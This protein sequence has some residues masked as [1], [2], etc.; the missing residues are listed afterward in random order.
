[1]KIINIFRQPSFFL[2][3]TL[4]FCAC[5]FLYL[6]GHEKL[7]LIEAIDNR[8]MNIMFKLRGPQPVSGQVVIVDIDEKSLSQI[9][10]WPWPR[11]IMA[12]ITRNLINSEARAIGFDIVFAEKDR[13]SPSFFF[14]NLDNALLEKIPDS[15]LSSLAQN[16]SFDYD[17]FFGQALSFGPTVLGYGFQLKNDGLKTREALPFP[18]GM[19]RIKPDGLNFEDL[20]FIRAYRASVNH[21]SV[22]MAESEGFMNVYTDHSGTAR[23][24]PLFMLMDDIP[25]P[26]LALEVFRIG[27]K[28]S[29]LTIHATDKI[30]TVKKPIIGIQLGSQFV[31]TDGVGQIFVNYRGPV[32]SFEY[33][34]AIDVLNKELMPVFKD[35]FVLVGTS[36]TGLFDLKAT[37]FSRAVPGVEI[38]A[39]IIDNLI[40]SD[41]YEY[42]RLTEIGL[43]YTLIV[44]G[45]LVLTLILSVLGPLAGGVGAAVFFAVSFAWNYYYFFLNHQYAGFTYP[46][47]SCAVI[48]LVI[49]MFNAFREGQ[50][51]RFIQDAFSHYVAPDVVAQLLKN[52]S[53]LSLTGEEKQLT[54]LFCDIRGFTT[55][56]EKMNSKDL[57]N[58]MNDFLTRMS[59][60]IMKNN[61]TVDKFIGD[62]VMAFWGAPKD[63]P[64]HAQNAVYTALQL[65]DELDHMSQADQK[66]KQLK[67]SV[68]IG[69]NT[70]LMNVGNFGSKQ[71]FDYTVMGDNVNLASRLEGA[72][73]NYGTTILI[74]QATQDI[75]RDLFY[76]RFI[77]KVQVKG[78]Q[79]PV[80]LY[81][82]LC[83]GLPSAQMQQETLEFE[84]G[85]RAYQNQEFKAALQMICALHSKNP[86]RLYQSYIDRIKG[87]MISPPSSSQWTGTERRSKL[88]ITRLTSK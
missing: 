17:A 77:D 60:I 14:K 13:S 12:A 75:I 10:Q 34:S 78:R 53:A 26:S 37:P 16:P 62:A 6:F 23:Q 55:L 67:I 83:K 11:N 5:F 49:S 27:M 69:I 8:A 50:A 82:P 2:G 40:K 86:T 35:K 46:M 81:E 52:P 76:C 44:V 54:V 9:G 29:S 3:C 71:R 45:G 20:N 59:Q 21:P 51:K 42:D 48:L 87:F 19:I 74:S 22:A 88:P 4:I 43:N 38:N 73:K 64:E 41:S 79:A 30:K 70:G 85:V 28:I 33:V 68:G 1:M 39:T 31:P 7:S 61:G 84:K 15:L 24:V 66:K 63:D 80:D 58:F 25:Y 65:K 56:S 72:N 57:G 47:A 36:S 32:N 18:S